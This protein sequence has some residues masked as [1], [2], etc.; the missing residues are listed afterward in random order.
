MFP[1]IS[2]CCFLNFAK[3]PFCFIHIFHVF[4]KRGFPRRFLLGGLCKPGRGPESV[5]SVGHG[6]NLGSVGE[7][8][9]GAMTGKDV[10]QKARLNVDVDSRG[11]FQGYQIDF[12]Y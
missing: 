5:T 9:R 10:F 3:Q 12:K 7:G 11:E 8:A 1:D 4:P 6:G 2:P